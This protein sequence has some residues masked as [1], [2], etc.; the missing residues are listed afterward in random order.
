MLVE[1]DY[2]SDSYSERHDMIVEVKDG[3]SLLGSITYMMKSA[4]DMNLSKDSNVLKI[5]IGVLCLIVLCVI[6]GGVAFYFIM[7]R[8]VRGKSKPVL[9]I[10][11]VDETGAEMKYQA[12]PDEGT[13]EKVK[14]DKFKS[15]DEETID[16]QI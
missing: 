15:N 11:G 1:N 7:T 4:E 10:D 8:F 13:K 3:G 2:S 5:V 6:L 12:K 14:I 9:E 16:D